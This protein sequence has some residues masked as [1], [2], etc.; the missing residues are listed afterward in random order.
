MVPEGWSN[1]K[2]GKVFKSRRERGQGG[3]PTIS[4]TLN[5]GLV[6]RESLDRKTDTNLSPEEHLLVGKGDIA[7]NMM[8]MWQGA[9]G[10][11]RFDALVSP[12]YVVLTPT[13]DI[14]PVFASYLFKSA[15]MIHLLWAYSYG[16]TKDRLRLYFPDFSLIPAALPPIEEQRR[17]GAL[18]SKWDRAIEILDN[19]IANSEAL[20]RALTQKLVSGATRL[21]EF[22]DRP[23]NPHP[24]GK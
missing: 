2:L 16:L 8:R 11:A 10:L 4:V 17:I 20:K 13:K 22:A 7:Y 23:W 5:N 19:L 12:A 18:V 1:T 15:R 6:L 14:D 21:P 3:L 9:S 24:F